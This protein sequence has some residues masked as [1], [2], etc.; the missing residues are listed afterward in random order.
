MKNVTSLLAAILLC[1]SC[2]NEQETRW[3]N[4]DLFE[5]KI[6]EFGDETNSFTYSLKTIYGEMVYINLKSSMLI[7][8]ETNQQTVIFTESSTSYEVNRTGDIEW[9]DISDSEIER[10]QK[11]VQSIINSI[12]LLNKKTVKALDEAE[13]EKTLLLQKLIDFIVDN[14]QDAEVDGFRTNYKY[15][16]EIENSDDYLSY[17]EYD[18][19]FSI[20]HYAVSDYF[21]ARN[22]AQFIFDFDKPFEQGQFRENPDQEWRAVRFADLKNTC[23]KWGI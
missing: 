21:A 20:N 6:I 13:N 11:R 8:N 23:S 17:S 15:K 1:I 7:I 18:K 22:L 19:G 3:D 4:L 14:S 9:G 12:A 10:Q 16:K 5:Q 2:N